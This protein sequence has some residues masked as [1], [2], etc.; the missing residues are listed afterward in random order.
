MP[1]VQIPSTHF[2]RT[3]KMQYSDVNAAIVR[4][5]VQN[6]IDAGAKTIA[7]TVSEEGWF[8]ADDDGEGMARERMISALL[9]FGGTAKGE[10]SIGGYGLAKE[11]ILFAHKS[12]FIHSRNILVDGH[13]LEYEMR[14][15][16]FRCGTKI[17]IE[18][19]PEFG[20]SHPTF[21]A[22]ARSV[23]ADSEF[24]MNVTLNGEVVPG[25][26]RGRTFRAFPWARVHC[27]KLP[28]GE[29]TCYALVRARG[30]L[31][32]KQYVGDLDKAVI[33]EITGNSREIFT[34]M[35]DR[36][37]HVY[38]DPLQK[39]FNEISVDRKSF[40]RKD[41]EP[42]LI[43]GDKGVIN[44]MVA[45]EPDPKA[46][47]PVGPGFCTLQ[48]EAGAPV[49]LARFCQAELALV[50]AAACRAGYDFQIKFDS[51]KYRKVPKRF[52]PAHLSQRL[53]RLAQVWKHC[54]KLVMLASGI[55][56]R[57]RIGWVLADD[58]AAVFADGRKGDGVAA[59]LLNPEH[60]TMPAP[61]E[62]DWDEMFTH[63]LVVAAHEIAHIE[64]RY[65]DEEFVRQ[66]EEL[67]EKALNSCGRSRAWHVQQARGEIV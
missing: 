50:P 2:L 24:S 13:A 27:R 55:R 60:R 41:T 40:D 34:A 37:N 47:A 7:L 15:G 58:E 67:L 56:K 51:G 31:M 66:S 26:P 30:L 19:H 48:S 14:E 5:V 21:L 52:E 29:R 10:N 43:R 42:L 59:F 44:E 53:L 63:L 46:A 1:N 12:Y 62:W 25:N 49:S 28:P 22:T 23:L 9:T 20:F 8:E 61:K 17:R 45:D 32:F 54:L 38:A 65:H 16:H 33:V 18:F 11:C 57:F 35:R 4:E 64:N 6:S 36:L 39:L 3:V